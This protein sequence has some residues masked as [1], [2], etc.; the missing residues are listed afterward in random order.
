MT[1]MPA[2]PSPCSE[3]PW[4]LANQGRRSKNA[5]YTKTNLRRLWN[6]LRRGE[7]MTC[8]PT[9]PRMVEFEGYEKT[10]DRTNTYE[11]TGAVILVQREATKFQDQCLAAQAIG[12]RDGLRRYL[13]A[14]PRGLLRDG[15]LV[16]VEGV[17]FSG[18]FNRE[19]RM[20]TPDLNNT[21]IAYPP[22]GEWKPRK[23]ESRDGREREER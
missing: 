19:L 8:H 23:G 2:N 1:L 13:R 9:D 21:T 6:G 12:A 14:H 3:C 16:V 7:R 18:L 5:F 20:A 17:A 22:L 10:I 15:I 4:R 11:C